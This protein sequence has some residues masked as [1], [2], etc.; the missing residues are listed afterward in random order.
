MERKWSLWMDNATKAAFKH[1]I[2][3][4]LYELAGDLVKSCNEK[5]KCSKRIPLEVWNTSS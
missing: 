1:F 4:N 3:E 5:S 2:S